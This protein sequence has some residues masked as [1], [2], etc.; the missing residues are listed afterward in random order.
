MQENAFLLRCRFDAMAWG[1]KA[2]KK[3][4]RKSGGGY[5]S[6]R[7]NMVNGLRLRNLPTG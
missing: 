1:A 7:E 6:P 2:L 5:L 4:T 3:V